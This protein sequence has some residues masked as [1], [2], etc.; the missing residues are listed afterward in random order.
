MSGPPPENFLIEVA[1]SPNIKLEGLLYNDRVL[2]LAA[3]LNMSTVG[4]L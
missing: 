4:F 3:E 2:T 1:K